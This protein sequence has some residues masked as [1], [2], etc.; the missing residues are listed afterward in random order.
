MDILSLHRLLSSWS[1]RLGA[2]LDSLSIRNCPVCFARPAPAAVMPL[3]AD[4]SEAG[5]VMRPPLPAFRAKLFTAIWCFARGQLKPVLAKQLP[6]AL[7]L[8]EIH[9]R[10][11]LIWCD[12]DNQI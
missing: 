12:D 2:Q 9:D 7:L 4:P 6:V 5:F 8:C 11:G 1:N 10:L 3:A